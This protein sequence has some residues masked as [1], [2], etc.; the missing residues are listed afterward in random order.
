MKAEDVVERA[1]T[2]AKDH[3][4]YARFVQDAETLHDALQDEKRRSAYH[5]CWFELEIVNALALDE[6]ESD[7]K[8]S[9][10]AATWNERYKRDAEELIA[11]LCAVLLQS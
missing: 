3:L 4:E 1:R 9:D 10:W 8:P 7:G 2:A 5:A 6:W 11:N